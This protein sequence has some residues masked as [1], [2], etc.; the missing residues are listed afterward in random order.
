M[1]LAM[2]EWSPV[3][4]A[5]GEGK[6]ILLVRSYEPPA[7]QFLLYPTFTFYT[8]AINKPEV[9]RQY[10]QP[11]FCNL[12]EAAGKHTMQR[13]RTDYYTDIDYFAEVD[14]FFP[15]NEDRLWKAIA[16]FYIWSPEH[17]LS[18]LHKTKAKSAYLWIVR[19]YKLPH[20]LLIGRVPMG[21][22]PATYTHHQD[23]STK[24]STPVLTDQNHLSIKQ[25]LM[26]L[27]SPIR[28]R[29]STTD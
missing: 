29:T 23:V 3:I 1:R 25:K 14:Q 24:G 2:K 8:N 21:G 22:P 11:Q 16:P 17:V 4:Q 12:A 6:Q 10:F 27:L 18:Y 9:L 13:A 26:D 28:D 20:P 5:L 15:I 7:T 19:T